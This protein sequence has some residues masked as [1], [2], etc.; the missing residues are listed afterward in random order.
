[1]ITDE[2][3]AYWLERYSMEWIRETA[4]LIWGLPDNSD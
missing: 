1:V 2:M 3:R 4:I